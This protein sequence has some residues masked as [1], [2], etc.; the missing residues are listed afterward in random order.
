M[1]KLQILTTKFENL[2]MDEDETILEFNAR[3]HDIA[4]TSFY[5][6]EKMSEEKLARKILISLPKRFNMKVTSIEEYQD[7]SS[8]RVDEIIG[9]L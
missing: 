7:L 3:L 5:L 6:G 8:I 1:S 9:S 2:K 4:N